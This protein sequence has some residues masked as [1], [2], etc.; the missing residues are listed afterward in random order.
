MFCIMG[1]I[2]IQAVFP[3]ERVSAHTRRDLTAES[4]RH[5][6]GA[7]QMV[8]IFMRHVYIHTYIIYVCMYVFTSY[9]G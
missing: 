5:N 9:C 3:P 6:D 7:H 4:W 8:Q 2:F 1:I